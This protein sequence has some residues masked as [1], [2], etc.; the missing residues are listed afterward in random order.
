MSRF[1]GPDSAARSPVSVVVFLMLAAAGLAADLYSKHYV[2]N[3]L[4]SDPKLGER[5]LA[6]P[7]DRT[8]PTAREAL[9]RFERPF[10]PGIRF[11]LTTNPGIVFSLNMPPAMV[12][13]A[14]FGTVM[15]ISVFFA[16]APRRAR[17]LQV[18]L[19]FIMAGALGNLYDRLFSYV[20]VPGN[21][22]P[23]CREVRDFID[24]S[25][26]YYRYVFNVADVLLVVGVALLVLHWL[27]AG[28]KKPQSKAAAAS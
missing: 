21:F 26:L 16:A 5:V 14:T 12:V 17:G 8:E 3:T 25:Q 24:A 2:F 27:V 19:A 15:L 11:T 22:P 6:S 28:R 18:G 13:A 10:I 7:I 9:R 1:I 4:L 20:Q 23:I